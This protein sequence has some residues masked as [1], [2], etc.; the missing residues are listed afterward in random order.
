M[1]TFPPIFDQKTFLILLKNQKIVSPFKRHFYCRLF[2]VITSQFQVDFIWHQQYYT[3]ECAK[4][5]TEKKRKNKRSTN[6]RRRKHTREEDE[7]KE[8]LSNN[9]QVL[10]ACSDSLLQSVHRGRANARANPVTTLARPGGGR[11]GQQPL[12]CLLVPDTTSEESWRHVSR[13]SVS[14]SYRTQHTRYLTPLL[15]TEHT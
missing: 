6:R 7:W 15:W 13:S 11:S 4:S 2:Y 12:H 1:I 5:R 8:N 9:Q 10:S 14:A 3:N